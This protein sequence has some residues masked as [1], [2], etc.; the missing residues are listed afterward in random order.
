MGVLLVRVSRMGAIREILYT[1]KLQ[2]TSSMW[3]SIV[4]NSCYSTNLAEA[5]AILTIHK[6]F[7]TALAQYVLPPPRT[8]TDLEM[9]MSANCSLIE[10]E[11]NTRVWVMVEIDRECRTCKFLLKSCNKEIQKMRTTQASFY[12]LARNKLAR[13]LSP[14]R[15]SLRQQRN[16]HR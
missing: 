7:F 9:E 13:F 12:S 5:Y 14:M 6:S 10:S 15:Y 16:V 11:I 4:F 2:C 3:I 8:V 1:S